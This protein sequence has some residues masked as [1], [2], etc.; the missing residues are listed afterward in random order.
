M[1]ELPLYFEMT[2]P[3]AATV[4]DKSDPRSQGQLSAQVERH[5][6]AFAIDPFGN[7]FAVQYVS[8]GSE[9]LAAVTRDGGSHVAMRLG[10]R[11]RAIAA[12]AA[13]IYVLLSVR[14]AVSG[15]S[16]NAQ[17]AVYANTLRD[18]SR[19]SEGDE[20]SRRRSKCYP[21]VGR[22]SL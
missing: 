8:G 16:D 19:Q 21:S 22:P 14:S 15:R 7:F 11:I 2:K 4:L 13:R 12:T 18:R 9:V 5:L 3:T 10:G 20:L 17:I 1:V 6:G